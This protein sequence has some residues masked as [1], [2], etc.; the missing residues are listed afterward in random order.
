[1][2]QPADPVIFLKTLKFPFCPIL[3]YTLICIADLLILLLRMMQMCVT[4]IV[5]KYFNITA[6]ALAIDGRMSYNITLR[7]HRCLLEQS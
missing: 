5:T 4:I 1:M 3:D 6:L 7:V 2:P